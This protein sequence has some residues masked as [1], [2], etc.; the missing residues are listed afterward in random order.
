MVAVLGGM[1]HAYRHGES[2]EWQLS[3]EL[4]LETL[5][6]GMKHVCIDIM[7]TLVGV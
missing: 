5:L 7:S 4:D 3:Y 1:W 6:G 2:S